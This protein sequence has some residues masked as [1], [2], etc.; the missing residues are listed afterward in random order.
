MKG[1]GLFCGILGS[2]VL[3][4]NV[5]ALVPNQTATVTVFEIGL[6]ECGHMATIQINGKY[7]ND[8]A[9]AMGLS[10]GVDIY[11]EVYTNGELTRNPPH[12]G[13]GNGLAKVTITATCHL[14]TDANGELASYTELL[15]MKPTIACT[16]HDNNPED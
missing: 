14:S 10:G 8:A 4:T 13:L 15:V 2:I 7:T 6:A 12:D 16:N 11:T 3:S 5:W 9:E 1:K